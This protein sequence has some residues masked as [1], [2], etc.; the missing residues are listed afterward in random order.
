MHEKIEAEEEA[1]ERQFQGLSSDTPSNQNAQNHD[2]PA[3]PHSDHAPSDPQIPGAESLIPEASPPAHPHDDQR[4]FGIPEPPVSQPPKLPVRE[5]PP[6]RQPPEIKYGRAAAEGRAKSEWG[7]GEDGYKRP[8][9]AADKMR[10][11][12]PY[13]VCTASLMIERHCGAD[14]L[15]SR[16][17]HQYKFRRNWGDF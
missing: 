5:T 6:E 12:L 17:V 2:H 1:R 11:N 14:E 8:K 15:W 13:K 10:K 9:T 7:Q 4:A 3:P 16:F